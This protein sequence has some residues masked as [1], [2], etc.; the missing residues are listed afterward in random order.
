M[1]FPFPAA[2]LTASPPTL[3]A[4]R[5]KVA[6]VISHPAFSAERRQRA[7]QLMATAS[8]AKQLNQW[9]ALALMESE[10]WED[11]ILLR[12]ESQGGTPAFPVYPY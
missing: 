11:V 7:E 9:A 2:H 10:Q 8:D 3:Q 12:E 1:A 6:A 5:A 4:A